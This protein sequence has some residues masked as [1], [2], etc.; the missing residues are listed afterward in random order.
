MKRPM[1][2]RRHPRERGQALAET[3]IVLTILVFMTL[4]TIE[5]GRAWMIANVVTTAARDG[6]RAAATLPR[7]DRLQSGLQVG[8]IDPN[9]PD[10]LSISQQIQ[11]EI[12][13]VYADGTPPQVV[14]DPDAVPLSPIK[15]ISVT[16]V[17]DVDW[18]FLG[19]LLG[20]DHF[21][22]ARTVTFRDEG[23]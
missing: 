20:Q 2:D 16:V 4:G 5:F 17:D 9:A 14:L 11:N 21:H 7:F 8:Q 3:G 12:A 18:L 15:M 1:R 10:W 13:S 22:V 19:S 6:A 23:R